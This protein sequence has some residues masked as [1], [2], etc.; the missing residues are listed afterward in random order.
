V[1]NE[2]EMI[3]KEMAMARFESALLTLQFPEG[4][5]RNIIKNLNQDIR[6]SGYDLNAG[7]RDREAGVL[8]TRPRQN[9]LSSGEVMKAHMCSHIRQ[10]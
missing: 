8:P 7:P 3:W 1:N 2:L 5:V 4:G 6:I 9:V 10:S